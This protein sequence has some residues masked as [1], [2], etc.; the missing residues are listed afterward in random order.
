MD[1]QRDNEADGLGPT[2]EDVRKKILALIAA[3][4]L[5][6]GHKLGA[7]RDLAQ[8]FE[9]SRSTLRQALS[10]LEESGAIRR[11]PGRGG[12]TFISPGKIDRDLS[13]IVGVPSLLRGQG[14]TAGTRLVS[15]SVQLADGPTQAA[16]GL[17]ETDHI[18][19]VVRIRLADGEPISFEHARFPAEMFPGLLERPL[20][21]SLYE[22]LSKHYDTFPD[23]AVEQIEIVLA[24]VDEARIMGVDV[25]SPL[26]SVMRTTMDLQGR[27]IEYSHDLFRGDRTRI[28]VR[29][30]GKLPTV[31]L[32]GERGRTV[33][34][35]SE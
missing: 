2:A 18:F 16:L 14:F 1:V 26:L 10:S 20:G 6:P 30:K 8:N 32:P 29:T 35:I 12:G 15:A 23:E 17:S 4:E 25:G 9:V 22:L 11:L 7:E 19:D 13:R 27:R 21:S 3:G 5:R 33:E 34:V 24:S 31:D 28:T